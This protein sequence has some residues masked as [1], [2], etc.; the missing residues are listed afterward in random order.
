MRARTIRSEVCCLVALGWL[1]HGLVTPLA[2][3]EAPP[4]TEAA[5]PKAFT[6]QHTIEIGGKSL[7]YQALAAETVLRDDAGKPEASIFSISY[8]LD[9][10]EQAARRP[11]TFVFNGGP[12]SSAAWL[13]LAAFGPRRLV[14]DDAT[15]PGAP[16]YELTANSSTLLPASDMVF[17]DPIGTGFSHALGE[18]ED[19]D[20]WSVDE[21]GSV[22][23][24][25]IRAYLTEHHRW[26]SPKYLLGESYGTIRVASLVEHLQLDILD[27]TALNGVI[28]ISSALG[29]DIVGRAAATDL[30]YVANLPTFA[31]VAHYHQR[32]A[33]PPDAPEDLEALLDE[34]RA[35]AAGDYLTALFEGSSLPAARRQEIAA[36][37]HHFTGLSEEYILRSNLRVPYD[38]FVKEL[39]RDEG[40]VLG[41]HDAR[42]EGKD[43]DE[44]G[45][46]VE[47]DPFLLSIAGPFVTA[48]NTYLGDDLAADFGR[49]YTLFN[50]QVAAG[51]KRP[52]QARWGAGP[53]DYTEALT[54]AAATNPDFHIFVASGE[55]D[56]AT[57]FFGTEYSFDHSGIAKDRITLRNYPS[58]H[59]IYLNLPS[60]AAMSADIQAMIGG[61]LTR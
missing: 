61:H 19:S 33:R 43:P 14:L 60:L 39:L 47:W 28:L 8:L 46:E 10:T 50:L 16:P 34:A 55:Y 53:V 45:A 1:V 40:K 49:P 56:L 29:R 17:V 26:A 22:L 51:W 27:S 44:A 58:G 41:V 31:A 11:I 38:H 9:G 36:R 4:S 3:A 23:A 52:S 30:T 18:H 20:F 15:K 5:A 13:H 7:S 21:D 6:T 35:F 48:M 54:I 57:T 12:G 37:L 42:F 25:F 32:L 2:A 59:M 24:R